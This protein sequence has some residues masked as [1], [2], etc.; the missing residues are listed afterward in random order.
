MV[1]VIVLLSG[2]G[3]ATTYYVAV[4]GKDLNDGLSWETAF[5]TIQK[6]INAAG[7]GKPNNYDTVWVGE[8]TYVTGPV[9]LN[10]D[11]Q[12]ICFRPNVTVE[13]KDYPAY[14]D[15][16]R[17]SLFEMYSKSNI[18]FDGN[19]T[20]FHMKN[21]QYPVPIDFDIDGGVDL[22]ADTISFEKDHIFLT[23]LYVRYYNN[24]YP[25][26]E[27]LKHMEWYFVIVTDNNTIRL[28]ATKKDAKRGK[29]IDLTGA[30]TGRHTIKPLSE[31]RHVIKIGSCTNVEIS[32]LTL[33]YSGGD[34]VAIW[35]DNK[36]AKD[37]SENITIKNV[38]CDHNFRTGIFIASVDGLLIEN[39]L[40][41]NTDGAPLG[42]WA[43][44]NFEPW[45]SMFR[46]KNIEVRNCTMENNKKY[47]VKLS[48]SLTS[49]SEDVSIL[50][51]DCTVVGPSDIT[52]YGLLVKTVPENGPGG[53]IRFR[54]CQVRN[55]TWGIGVSAKS[56]ESVAVV[57]DN[58]LVKDTLVKVTKG[59][60]AYAPVNV[61]AGVTFSVEKLGGVQFINCRV[62]DNQNR[63][64]LS[65]TC[66]PKDLYEIH[67]DIYVQ[68]SKR[69]GALWDW[70]GATLHNVDITLHSKDID[71]CKVHNHTEDM[72]YDTKRGH[73]CYT[74]D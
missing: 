52:N 50:V 21:E 47:G 55:A 65:T 67:G 5:A 45:G 73:I 36:I 33:E 10:N 66:L 54:N 39:C 43:G 19:S 3:T 13:A 31:G 68:N 40:V 12:R 57:F 35:G 14:F 20:I 26:V 56:S 69:K 30:S 38:T 18:I 41:K 42:P 58:C 61:S 2:M 46:L 29:Q 51:E 63:P 22:D 60:P 70:S 9:F 37:Y 44:F 59:G 32:D 34:G 27:P 64:A 62:I 6:G 7:G 16:P 28:A 25:N 1:V 48:G 49:E 8:G 72:K 53:E 24:G 74:T 11:N 17:D 71:T 15:G 23:G 4:D